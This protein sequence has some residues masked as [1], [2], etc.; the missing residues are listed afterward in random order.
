MATPLGCRAAT[1]LGRISAKI[2]TMIVMIAVAVGTPAS[3]PSRRTA[4]AAASE[5]ARIFTM[6]LPRRIVTRSREEEEVNSRTA[7]AAG[8]SGRA[9]TTSARRSWGR[10]TRAGRARRKEEGRDPHEERDHVP[11][12]TRRAKM[13]GLRKLEG[14]AYIIGEFYDLRVLSNIMCRPSCR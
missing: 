13:Q 9:R 4:R 1:A 7:T 14:G 10:P 11:A 8:T 3:K 5:A 12:P 2:R 6:L